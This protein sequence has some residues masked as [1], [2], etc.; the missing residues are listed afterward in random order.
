M[1]TALLRAWGVSGID[2]YLEELDSLE[3]TMVAVQHLTLP[4]ATI[5]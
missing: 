3:P 5:L 2:S 4:T 1:Q